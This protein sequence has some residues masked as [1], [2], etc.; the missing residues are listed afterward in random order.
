M[1]R[2]KIAKEFSKY[3]HLIKNKTFFVQVNTGMENSKSGIYVN[4]LKD[5]LDF[6]IRDIKIPIAG[7]MCIPPIDEDA[8]Y[9]FKLLKNLAEK[10]HLKKLSIGM[11]SDYEIAL[12]F[13]PSY[14]RLGTLLFGKR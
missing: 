1:D 4:E 14:I 6:C 13:N 12:K 5:F 2:E 7:L 10:N 11:S 3:K 9:H 8:S